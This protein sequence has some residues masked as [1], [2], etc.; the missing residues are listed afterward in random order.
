MSEEQI[1]VQLVQ[2]RAELG[3]SQRD[4]ATRAGLGPTSI[5]EIERGLHTPTL[6]TLLRWAAAVGYDLT[7]TL[8]DPTSAT[9]AQ[10][11]RAPAAESPAEASR[12]SR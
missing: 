5:S 3:L 12:S 10:L 4:V 11:P 2:R 9:P 8:T 7:L 6:P 1:I